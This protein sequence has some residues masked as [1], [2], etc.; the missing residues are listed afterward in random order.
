MKARFIV[1]FLVIAGALLA[2]ALTVGGARPDAV[3]VVDASEV[4]AHASSYQQRELRVRG[5]VKGG[6][7]LRQGDRADFVVTLNGSDIPVRYDGNTQLPDTFNDGAAVRVDGMLDEQGRLVSHKVEAK[8]ASKYSAEHA[9][10]LQQTGYD[11]AS[12]PAQSY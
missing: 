6:S 7:I 1:V 10:R 3:V 12:V 9:E 2:L 4:V 8:C 5:F 11:A